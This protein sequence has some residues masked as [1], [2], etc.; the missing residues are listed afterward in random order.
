MLA[1]ATFMKVNFFVVLFSI[2]PKHGRLTKWTRRAFIKL[3]VQNLKRHKMNLKLRIF[4]NY[5]R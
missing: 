5:T 4:S 1:V 2:H 3:F